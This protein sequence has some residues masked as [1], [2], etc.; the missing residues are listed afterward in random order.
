MK[1]F[2]NVKSPYVCKV[3]ELTRD[4]NY[5]YIISEIINGRDLLTCLENY[6][7]VSEVIART[8][9]KKIIQGINSIH[10][11]KLVHRDVRLE[12][13]FLKFKKDG[14]NDIIDEVKI[15]DI[16]FGIKCDRQ[17]KFIMG[18][19]YYQSPESLMKQP[20]T[21]KHDIWA[22]GVMLYVILTGD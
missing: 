1:N 10:D 6:G 21:N 13:V 7:S 8:W 18:C 14:A 20:H 17:S 9:F 2:N 19:E 12:N 22:L 5:I 4:N 3:L 15:V 16:G 11:S